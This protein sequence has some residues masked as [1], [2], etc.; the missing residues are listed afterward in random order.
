VPLLR[1]RKNGGTMSWRDEV[2]ARLAE[3]E[4]MRLQLEETRKSAR[5]I[6]GPEGERIE[7]KIKHVIKEIS[8][9]IND[10]RGSLQ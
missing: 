2:E 4:L 6:G 3:L 7:A 8:E 9:Q 5:N 10:L 1:L